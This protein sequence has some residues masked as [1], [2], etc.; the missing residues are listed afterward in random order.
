MREEGRVPDPQKRKTLSISRAGKEGEKLESAL[1]LEPGSC[2]VKEDELNRYSVIRVEGRRLMA[3][4]QD[5]K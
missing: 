4:M 2:F 1:R 5:A 3:D